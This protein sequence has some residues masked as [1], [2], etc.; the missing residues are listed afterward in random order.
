MAVDQQDG[1]GVVQRSLWPGDKGADLRCE[2]SIILSVFH[3]KP[4][5]KVTVV[6]AKSSKVH[7]T[8]ARL[9]VDEI[10]VA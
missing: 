8:I 4:L 5:T 2:Q 7:A 10:L 1:D 9:F 3:V 6:S